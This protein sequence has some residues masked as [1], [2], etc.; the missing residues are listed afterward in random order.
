[1]DNVRRHRLVASIVL[2]CDACTVVYLVLQ[3]PP[4][5]DT[6]GFVDILFLS[7]YA[8][9]HLMFYGAMWYNKWFVLRCIHVLIFLYPLAALCVQWNALQ[10]LALVG[11]C[12]IQLLWIVKGEC[13]LDDSDP[14]AETLEHWFGYSRP[15]RVYALLLTVAL[16]QATGDCD[17][18]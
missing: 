16:A 9:T 7:T 18:L 13:I 11:L 10:M 3:W 6:L 12:I 17:A 5:G 2:G 4:P 8:L 1:M 14:R 15:L